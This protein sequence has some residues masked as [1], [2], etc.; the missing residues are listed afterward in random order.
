MTTSENDSGFFLEHKRRF[1]IPWLIVEWSPEINRNWILTQP[2]Y[3][4][5]VLQQPN[6]IHSLF[7]CKQTES[8]V[9]SLPMD[10]AH[11][12]GQMWR[13][14]A[15]IVLNATASSDSSLQKS[16]APMCTEQ[17]KNKRLE[18]DEDE[19][20]GWRQFQCDHFSSIESSSKRTR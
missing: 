6:F 3:A 11:R 1:A 20:G 5:P 15:S 2:N 12:D 9:C 10:M 16:R 8:V 14:I 7:V 18:E 19:G 17:Q 13:V 4:L